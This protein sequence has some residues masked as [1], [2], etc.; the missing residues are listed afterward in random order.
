M[1]GFWGFGVLRIAL[2]QALLRGFVS[3]LNKLLA[4]IGHFIVQIIDFGAIH[5][6]IIPITRG[7][8]KL[9]LSV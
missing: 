5:V 8:Q 3:L 9:T 1:M 2:L 7:L 6:E 4:D